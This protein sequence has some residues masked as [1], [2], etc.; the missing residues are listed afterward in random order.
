MNRWLRL[1]LRLKVVLVLT[2]TLMSG[3]TASTYLAWQEHSGAVFEAAERHGREP[4]RRIAQ[5][6]T[7]HIVGYDY[8]FFER[9]LE[10]LVRHEDIVYAQILRQRG[11]VMA[12]IG[13]HRRDDAEVRI[14]DLPMGIN[15][16]MAGQLRIGLSTRGLHATLER[17]KLNS[18]RR[19]AIVILLVL[20]EVVR[21]IH[22]PRHLTAHAYRQRPA[23]AECRRCHYRPPATPLGA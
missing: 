9:R 10:E 22:L 18:H 7:Y 13:H 1:G 15:D 23:S 2:L 5:T 14:F 8:H 17:Q 19:Q 21:R 20:L 6:L 4:S 11:N 12:E 3:L 16:K